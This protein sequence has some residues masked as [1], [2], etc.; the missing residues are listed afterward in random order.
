LQDQL[1]SAEALRL[2]KDYLLID[3][4]HEQQSDT[5]AQSMVC[6]KLIAAT[7]HALAMTGTI[8]G[9]Y[10]HNLYALLMR[11]NPDALREEGFE[12]GKVLPFSEVYGRIDRVVTTTEDDPDPLDHQARQVHAAGQV[13]QV[14]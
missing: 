14:P 1:N 9:G 11:L 3:E 7:R 13:G 10:A 6:S 4:T 5:S 8:I 2:F 12:W